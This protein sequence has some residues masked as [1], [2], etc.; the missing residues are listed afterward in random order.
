MVPMGL[1]GILDGKVNGVSWLKKHVVIEYVVWYKRAVA[2]SA[3][4]ESSVD[5]GQPEDLEM[6]E[7]AS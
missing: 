1:T 4:F 6:T 2:D 3:E 7:P 5:F